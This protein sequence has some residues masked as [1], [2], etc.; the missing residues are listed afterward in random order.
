MSDKIAFY[1]IRD[2]AG[3]YSTGGSEPRFTKGGKAWNTMAH[4]K[5][6]L[7]QLYTK[8]AYTGCSVVTFT[9]AEADVSPVASLVKSVENDKKSVG[10]H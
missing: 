3:K 6:H 2:S 5:A 1:K 9:V 4:L 8:H 10:A 7:A